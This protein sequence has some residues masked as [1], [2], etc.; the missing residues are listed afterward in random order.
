MNKRRLWHLLWIALLTPLFFSACGAPGEVVMEL[1]TDQDGDGFSDAD[2]AEMGTD[3]TS[4][5]TDGDGFLDGA[6]VVS[7]TDPTD[8]TDHP[9]AGGWP[10]DACRNDIQS[11]GNAA[12]QIT[13]NF[14]LM[15]QDGDTVKLHDF[16]G[17]V[18]L[19]VGAAFW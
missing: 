4:Q 12:G 6:E 10:I 16:C 8:E 15:N 18:V 3:P 7:F 13:P 14:E 1:A 9:Y 19:L 11:T 5:D 2:E 17:K